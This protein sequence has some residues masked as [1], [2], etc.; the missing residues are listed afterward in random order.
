MNLQQRCS[1]NTICVHWTADPPDFQTRTTAEQSDKLSFDAKKRVRVRAF[2]LGTA[3][4][5]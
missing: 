5:L 3:R 2:T 4:A 1:V